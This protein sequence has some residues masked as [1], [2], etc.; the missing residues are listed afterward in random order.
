LAEETARNVEGRLFGVSDLAIAIGSLVMMTAFLYV[1]E[2][3]Y[4]EC[5]AVL[6]AAQQ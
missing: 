1:P 2:V 6:R 4:R 5:V 3:F